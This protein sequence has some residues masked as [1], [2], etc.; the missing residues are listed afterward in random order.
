MVKTDIDALT[1]RIEKLEAQVGK[2]TGDPLVGHLVEYSNDLG[3]SLAGND[4]ILPLM[5]RLDELETYLDPLF[6]E[7]EACSLGVKMSLVENQFEAV[8]ENQES[9]ENLEKLKGSLEK[10]NLLKME[11]LRPRMAELTRIQLE[12]RELGEDI[13]EQTLDLVQKYN[14]IISSLTETFIQADHIVSKAEQEL[15][16]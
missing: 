6:G 4:R 11:E 16:M 13:T 1:R 12:Q 2:Q 5:K 3:N 15:K 14:D 10:G 9:L 8:R 7:K